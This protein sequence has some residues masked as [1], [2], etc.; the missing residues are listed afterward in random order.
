MPAELTDID[1]VR[2]FMQK[3]FSDK[4]QDEDLEVLI[5]QSSEAI[6]RYCN[7]QFF[8]ETAVMK[9]FEFYPTWG[10][11]VVDV[12][13]TEFRAI[14]S[15]TIDPDLT[16]VALTAAHYRPHPYPARDGTFFCIKFAELPE[17]VVPST[18]PTSPALPFLTRRVDVTGDWGVASVPDGLEH[19]ANLTVEE[20]AKLHTG[21]LVGSEH[22]SERVP[23]DL[24]APVRWGLKRWIRPSA[25]A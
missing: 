15:I 25:E 18:L 11:E 10:Y 23:L 1:S 2:Q 17:P 8:P 24:P 19:W 13:P 14:T 22:E 3:S 7:R 9:S 16:P 20:W 5:L 6:E 4:L 12:K 21:L